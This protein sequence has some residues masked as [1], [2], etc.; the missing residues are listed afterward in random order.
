MSYTQSAAPGE[1]PL[2][3]VEKDMD[4]VAF[5]LANVQLHLTWIEEHRRSFEEARII[6]KVGAERE[7]EYLRDSSAQARWHLQRLKE[8]LLAGLSIDPNKR[9][10]KELTSPHFVASLP[11]LPG[12]AT[13]KPQDSEQVALEL[14]K[15]GPTPFKQGTSW[16]PSLICEAISKGEQFPVANSLNPQN[17]AIRYVHP[18]SGRA[19]IRDTVTGEII[20]A[21]D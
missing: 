9:V 4:P 17:P 5:A 14:A 18:A 13:S 12:E 3:P 8:L 15:R 20:A 2:D 16:T 1:H 11:P 19:V 7:L 10:H 6:N 21:E